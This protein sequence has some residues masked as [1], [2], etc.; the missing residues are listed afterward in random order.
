MF[1]FEK[2]IK[3]FFEY[4]IDK[5]LKENWV[6]VFNQMA[7][8][9]RKQFPE[10]LLK[11]ARPN[12]EKKLLEYRLANYR[13]ITY[14]SINKSMDDVYRAV[15]GVNFSIDGESD[16]T[17]EFIAGNN[18][19]SDNFETYLQ[20]KVLRRDIEDPNGF[21][22]WVPISEDF[23]AINKTITPRPLLTYSEKLYYTDFEN[24]FSF[25]SSEVNKIRIGDN[26][27]DGKVYYIFTKDSF[28]KYVQVSAKEDDVYQL[29]P[30]YKH[31][32]GELPV[33]ILGGDINDDNYFNSFFSSY[34]AYGD[35]AIS[36]FSDWQAQRITSGFPV[37]EEF[38]ADCE[39][40]AVVRQSNP[41]PTEEEKFDGVV[42][43]K[44][45]TSMHKSPL[46]IV[47]RRIPT[48]NSSLD[49]TLDASIPSR[50][51]INTPVEGVKYAGEVWLTL[52]TKAEES[53]QQSLSFA[54][55]SGK[56]VELTNEG[57]YSMLTKICNN[58]FDNIYRK[59][60]IF[61][62]S[63]LTF[64]PAEK[65][66]ITI[67]KPTSFRLTTEEDI[68]NEITALNESN[69]AVMFKSEANK[70]LAKK[71]FSGN[72]LA[73][74]IFD[75]TTIIDPLFTYSIPEKTQMQL[76]NNISMLAMV[77]S[78]NCYG[79]LN[80]IASDM[81][82]DVFMKATND[83][84]IEKFNKEIV[85]YIPEAQTTLTDPNGNPE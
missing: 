28:Y 57:K 23:D 51:Y 47:L 19:H 10:K 30:I 1:E 7:V 29:Q 63:Y 72:P 78:I 39:I 52:I 59:S 36:S 68:L 76:A 21:L 25:L 38:A 54:G 73:Q 31:D 37:I 85:N 60:L 14:G 58:Y 45:E 75:L 22:V 48:K 42:K 11:T 82:V 16:K 55:D 6:E 80:K 64:T 4:Q 61:I 17:K 24:V 13:P 34:L 15:G 49:D 56:K 12:E 69:A 74:K 65:I 71:R 43:T 8:H 62:E 40:K 53:L 46:G 20:K 33:I 77:T 26:F 70:D 41:I 18:F 66:K 35:E 32:I 79:V 84:I 50:R 67:N 27:K 44:A 81:T 9:T 83:S 5:K 2:Y 3:N